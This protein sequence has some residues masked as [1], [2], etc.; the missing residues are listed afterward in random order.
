MGSSQLSIALFA[1][2]C[3]AVDN[4]LCL[5]LLLQCCKIPQRAAAFSIQIFYNI[6]FHKKFIQ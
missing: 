4:V 3:M 6:L 2:Q 1:K 5:S